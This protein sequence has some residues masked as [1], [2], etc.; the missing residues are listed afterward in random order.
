MKPLKEMTHDELSIFYQNAK[1]EYEACKEKGLKLDMSRGKPGS[2]QL[3]LTIDILTILN[4]AEQCKVD[5][6]DARNYGIVDGLPVCKALFADILSVKP[7]QVFVGGNSSLNLMYDIISKAYTHGMLHSEKPWS[8]L[9]EVKFLCPV[10]GYDRHFRIS[11]HFGTKLIPIPLNEN[12]PDMDMVEELVKDSAV[13]GMWCVP[14]YSN[15][16]GFIYSDETIKRIASL[17]P[18]APDFTIMWDNAYCVHEFDGDFIPFVNIIDECEKYGNPDMVYQFCSTSKITVP[19]SGVACFSSSEAN[20]DYQRSLITFQT[21]GYDKMNQLRTVLYLKNREHTIEIMKKHAQILKP[22]FDAVI[23]YLD[24]EIAPLGFARYHKPKGGY[25]ISF[26]TLEGTATRTIDL[27][28]EAG[29]V[30]TP[31]GSAF[32]YKHDPDDTNIRIAP[33]LPS[34]D[35]LTLATEILCAC[36]KLAAAE[37]LLG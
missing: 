4:S 17:K 31:A 34:P 37:K 28:K 7:T 19:G 30:M 10:P 1:A 27:A 21:I 26:N 22:K 5:G 23:E 16:D 24:K 14:K 6:V 13:R 25:F 8:K 15:P 36:A 32:P 33:S 3:D 20:I 2:E 11:E 9:D 12:G 29:L 18:A 35:E